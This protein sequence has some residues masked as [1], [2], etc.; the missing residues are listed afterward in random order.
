MIYSKLLTTLYGLRFGPPV[1]VPEADAEALV[2]I[3]DGVGGFDL[4]SYG[5]RHVVGQGGWAGASSARSP[6]GMV[7]GGGMPT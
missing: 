2:L 6:G 3:A 5:L 1:A 4:T 7:G